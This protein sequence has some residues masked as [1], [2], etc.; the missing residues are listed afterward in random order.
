MFD[1]DCIEFFDLRTGKEM[2]FLKKNF[3][4]K[5][6]NKKTIVIEIC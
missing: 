4:E 5:Q 6:S 1:K 2:E 3:E